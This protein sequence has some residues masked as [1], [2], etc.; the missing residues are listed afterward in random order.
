MLA[1][2]RTAGTYAPAARPSAQGEVS[3]PVRY[4]SNART[5]HLLGESLIV[6]RWPRE[7]ISTWREFPP[8]IEST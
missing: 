1:A 5:M 6:S 7:E 2:R 3:F 4:W 8:R